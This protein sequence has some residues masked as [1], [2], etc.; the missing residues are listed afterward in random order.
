MALVFSIPGK[1]FL[2]GEY[3]ALHGGPTLV[4]LSKPCFELKAKKGSGSLGIIHPESPAG[5][6]IAAH[7]EYFQKFD[8]EFVDPYQGLGG[9][10]ASTAQFLGAY[11]LWLYKEPHLQ[12]MEQVFDYKH[13]LATYTEFAWNGQG[14]P[15]S[16]A[17]LIGQMKGSLTFF[18][19]RRGM[20]SVLGWPFEDLEFYLIHTG[21]KVPTHEHLKTLKEFDSSGLEKAFAKVYESFGPQNSEGLIEGVQAYAAELKT[22]GFTCEPT[23]ELL[24]DI[25]ALEGVKAA[26]GCG[27]LGSDVLFVITGRGQATALENYCQNKKLK[28][29]SSHRQISSGLQVS[30]K[31]NL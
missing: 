19:K 14:T 16:G 24:E 23:L 29:V 1:T 21:N 7:S 31:E 8:L 11:A 9:F 28:I 20:L 12:G 25:R 27:A 17:D 2:V 4:A 10:G 13:L 22:L 18:E 26:K 5:K 15:P 30:E 6:F 3:L